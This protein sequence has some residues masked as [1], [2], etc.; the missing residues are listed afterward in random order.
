MHADGEANRV[1]RYGS[2]S[3]YKVAMAVVP[4]GDVHVGRQVQ[5]NDCMSMV[6]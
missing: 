3:P 5:K 6:G 1:S 2:S 4:A